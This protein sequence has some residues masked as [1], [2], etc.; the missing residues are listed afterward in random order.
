[1]N[2]KTTRTTRTTRTYQNQLSKGV[3][4]Y[5]VHILDFVRFYLALLDLTPHAGAP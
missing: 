1:M 5:I 3:F 4:I 2:T